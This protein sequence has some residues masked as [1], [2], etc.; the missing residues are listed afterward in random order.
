MSYTNA[1]GRQRILDDCG[2]ALVPLDVALAEL[3]EAYDHFDEHTAD[4]FEAELFKPLQ[5]AY[6]AVAHARGGF[7]ARY[8]FTV[9]QPPPPPMPG[10]RDPRVAL[11]NA[12]TSIRDADDVL[13][14]LQ[15]SM[16]PVEVGDVELRN[17]LARSRRLLDPL[18]AAC[19]SLSRSFG[20]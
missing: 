5:A 13:A 3:G 10:L 2:S 8:G 18:P 7:A 6:S 16:L 9:E 17:D 14:E 19:R 15:D 20:R 12:A 4:R 1:S 11:A